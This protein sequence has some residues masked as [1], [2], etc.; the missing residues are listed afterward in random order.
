[1]HAYE[2]KVSNNF[3]DDAALLSLSDEVHDD[4]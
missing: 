3:D 1:M 4:T 2:S